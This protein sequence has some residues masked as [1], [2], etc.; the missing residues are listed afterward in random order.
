MAETDSDQLIRFLLP[1]AHTRGAIIRGSHIFAEMKRVHGLHDGPALLLGQ[2]LL[3]SILL[4]SVSKGGIR[5][6]LQL[7]GIPENDMPIQR[8][9]AEAG[10]G[11]VRGYLHWQEQHVS[12]RTPDAEPLAGWMGTPVRLSTVRDLGIGQPYISTIQHDS[13]YL[14]DY[15]LQYLNQS[16]QIHADVL[17]V[18]DLGLMIE[19]MP[20]SDQEHWFSA[21]EA[22]AAISDE[23]LTS[24]SP[25]EILKAFDALGCQVVGHDEYG[26]RCRCS[27][28]SMMA[29]LET[30]EPD[31]LLELA[32]ENGEVTLS[33]QYCDN[34]VT[35]RISEEP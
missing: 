19:A 26:Y 23:R 24:E 35:V 33:C 2:S 7:D 27:K 8:L 15:L 4:L 21:V 25:E 31:E 11:M 14:A 18:G 28:E 1:K 20:G 16:V 34:V 17:L 29:V 12:S 3:A 30:M 22:M 5:Q 13:P 10:P 9:F 6:V 32:D